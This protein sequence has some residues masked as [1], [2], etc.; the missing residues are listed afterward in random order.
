MY[1]QAKKVAEVQAAAASQPS[2]STAPTL[3]AAPTPQPAPSA[4]STP[5]VAAGSGGR[6]V[7]APP[8]GLPRAGTLIVCP[9]SVLHQWAKEARDKVHSFARLSLH[10][11][12]GKVWGMC[13]GVW[14]WGF[15]AG[16]CVGFVWGMCGGDAW[17]H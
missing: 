5:G 9:T 14:V 1:P 6:E 16:L 7:E 15:C 8:P 4:A 17:R 12:H 13:G 2:A 10:M 3:P 11:Y